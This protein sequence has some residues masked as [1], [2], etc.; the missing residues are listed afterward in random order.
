VSDSTFN[1]IEQ[2]SSG[3]DGVSSILVLEVI[4]Q[5]A[6]CFR[7]SSLVS[8]DWLGRWHK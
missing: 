4:T 1:L 2:P 8:S 7:Q 3:V 6:D 5:E